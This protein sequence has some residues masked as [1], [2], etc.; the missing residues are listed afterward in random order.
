MS[1]ERKQLIESL[2]EAKINF[3]FKA[4]ANALYESLDTPVSLGAYLR[5][6]YGEFTQ[7]AQMQVPPEG[8]CGRS[9]VR[10]F[11]LT[12]HRYSDDRQAADFLRKYSKLPT[13]INTAEVAEQT[14]LQ[15]EEMCRNT[16]MT[17]T[18]AVKEDPTLDAIYVHARHLIA[19]I[20]GE[21]DI[22]EWLDACRFGPGSVVAICGTSDVAKTSS[23]IG[24]TP[25]LQPFTE[26]LLNK[27]YPGWA[28]AL[29]Y[30]GKMPIDVDA[31]PGGKFGTVPKTALT[32]RC[33][34]TQPLL[35]AFLQTGLGR[36]MR[37]RLSKVGTRLLVDGNV[38]L[39]GA[40]LSDQSLNQALAREGSVSGELATIDLS[41]ASDLIAR[42]IVENLLPPD[43][44]H[45][46]NLC[47]THRIEF[48]GEV[49]TLSRFSSMGNGFTFELESLIFYAI[50][51]AT[52]DSPYSSAGKRHRTPH[53]RLVSVYGDDIV[54]N[55]HHV[56]DV[57]RALEG[58]GFVVNA[59]KSFHSGYFRESCGADWFHGH[60]VRPFFL[61]EEITTVPQCITVANG[62]RR[63]AARRNLENGYHVAYAKTYFYALK[64]IP[65][66]IRKRI[67]VGFTATDDYIFGVRA[68][69][70]YRLYF[71]ARKIPVENWYP[72]MGAALYRAFARGATNELTAG[73]TESRW[74]STTRNSLV[75]MR[76]YLD[77][78]LMG[79]TDK[80]RFTD[81]KIPSKS[82]TGLISDYGRDDGSWSCRRIHRAQVTVPRGYDGW[83]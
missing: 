52:I 78:S 40:D 60:A 12:W 70:G 50:C 26:V 3:D 74:S 37:N 31:M 45:A 7:L 9:V 62:M 18:K 16:N 5:L 32:D 35:N 6:K 69:A 73:D 41:N 53:D 1:D 71:A 47:R 63:V 55:C 39:V 43:W 80:P 33:I 28:K 66:K 19:R 42:A 48:R 83:I 54:V 23:A 2:A 44:L 30:G 77:M 82:K 24:V 38:R 72:A 79:F 61:K 67:A 68:R 21:L 51:R 8:Y 36:I 22:N 49:K 10:G 25:E 11:P 64:Q 57:H 13:G 58:F 46:M 27:E 29:T 59:K 65:A 75:R 15:C 34:E 17:F 56:V 76:D 81:P 20:L 4:A 14:F